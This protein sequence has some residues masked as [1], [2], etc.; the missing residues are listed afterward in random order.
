M[1]V[2]VLASM[3]RV[4][5]S[6]F[7]GDDVDERDVRLVPFSRDVQLVSPRRDIEIARGDARGRPFVAVDPH[8]SPFRFVADDV[9]FADDACQ[10]DDHAR[11][12]TDLHVRRRGDGVFVARRL[13]DDA[14]RARREAERLR[15]CA[16]LPEVFSIEIERRVRGVGDHLQQ[17][18]VRRDATERVVDAGTRGGVRLADGGANVVAIR[19]G[20]LLQRFVR[21]R[22]VEEDVAVRHEAVGRE[23]VLERRAVVARLVFLGR[24]VEV[25]T[26]F[27][28]DVVGKRRARQQCQRHARRHDERDESKSAPHQSPPASDGLVEPP[29]PMHV[30]GPRANAASA[31]AQSGSLCELS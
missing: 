9:H 31:G 27:V 25:K 23:K 16:A 10:L 29:P 28:G 18:D 15:A 22:D 5:G 11:R 1:S 12:R 26:R 6:L 8:R 21:T 13:D 14:V 30:S 3:F 20:E 17:G 2:P 7:V 19:V 4:G 24:D